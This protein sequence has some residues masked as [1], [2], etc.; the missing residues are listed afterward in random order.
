MTSTPVT[1][2]IL[3]Y[4]NAKYLHVIGQNRSHMTFSNMHYSPIAQPTGQKS[5]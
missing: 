1:I 2:C 4:L 5:F 3:L